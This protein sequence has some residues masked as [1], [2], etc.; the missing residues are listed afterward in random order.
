MV[1]QKGGREKERNKVK[2]AA[3]RQQEG[4]VAGDLAADIPRI[5]SQHSKQQKFSKTN[6][7]YFTLNSWSFHT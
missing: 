1:V 4:E 2:V 7:F 5:P 6:E 3:H